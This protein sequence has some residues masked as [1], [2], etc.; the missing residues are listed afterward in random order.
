VE[1]TLRAAGLADA[2]ATVWDVADEQLIVVAID[3]DG[4]Q[5]AAG[6]SGPTGSLSGAGDR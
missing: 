1:Q 2:D 6:Q 3:G 4:Q 5:V